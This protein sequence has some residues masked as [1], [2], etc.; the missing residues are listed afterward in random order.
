VRPALRSTQSD[1]SNPTRFDVPPRGEETIEAG[2]HRP[3]Q[4][5]GEFEEDEEGAR[6]AAGK[7]NDKKRKGV[8]AAAKRKGGAAEES[9]RRGGAASWQ[10]WKDWDED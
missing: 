6:V 10:R 5:P 1:G 7:R 3:A 8:A 4:P 2:P 9:R